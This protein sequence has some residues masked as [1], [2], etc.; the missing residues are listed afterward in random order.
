MDTQSRAYFMNKM[1]DVYGPGDRGVGIANA[2]GPA[3]GSFDL[4]GACRCS[5]GSFLVCMLECDLEKGVSIIRSALA[6]EYLAGWE[7]SPLTVFEIQLW[8]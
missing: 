1:D 4:V 2:M 8:N 3:G 6:K 7:Y 5:I